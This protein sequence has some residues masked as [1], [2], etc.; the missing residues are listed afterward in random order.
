MGIAKWSCVALGVLGSSI[1]RADS[2]QLV[3]TAAASPSPASPTLGLMAGIGVPDAATLSLAWRPV[4]ALRVELGV[5]HDYVSPGVRG[6]L[7]YIPFSSW[8]TPTLSVGYG[9]FLERDANQAV[10][11]ISGDATFDSPMLDH[12]G[13]DYAEAHVGL[14][15]G[16]KHVTFYLHAGVTRVTATIHDVAAAAMQSMPS[17]G[18]SSGTVA[19]TS[20]DPTVRLWAPS[21]DLG[22]VVYLF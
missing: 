5:A 16:R 22:L 17:S 18:G 20:T 21:L 3:A 12:F 15:L 6:G 19:I 11:T 4:R 7:T 8:A 9:H 2:T 1:A 13:Y 14:E 10:R